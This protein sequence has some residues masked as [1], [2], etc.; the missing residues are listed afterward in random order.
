VRGVTGERRELPPELEEL[1]VRVRDAGS[2]P[3]AVGF[4]VGTTEQVAQ[5]GDIADGV[6]VGSRLVRAI[7]EASSFEQ[8]LSEAESFLRRAAVALSWTS[9]RG[10][11]P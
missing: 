5:V 1:V 10:E 2:V 11:A 9:E 8:G 7:S 6:I 3:V 4:G